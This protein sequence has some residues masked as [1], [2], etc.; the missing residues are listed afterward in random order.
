MPWG[1]SWPP[2]RCD[3][4]DAEAVFNEVRAALLERDG[5]VPAGQVPPAFARFAPL[6]GTPKGGTP[7]HRTVAN[8][9]H[10]IQ[11]MLDLVWPLRWWDPTRETLYVLQAL[12]QDAFGRDGWTHDLTGD[13]PTR[14]TPAAALVFDELYRAVNR[15]DRLRV[16]PTVSERLRHDSVYRLSFGIEDWPQDR[17]DTFSLF[18]GADDGV[19]TGLEYDVGM[20]GEVCDDGFSQQWILE[21]RRFRMTF[22]TGALAGYTVGG[23]RLDFTTAA[24]AGQ[25]DYED[26]FTAEVVDG[27]GE[28]VESFASGDYGPK[29]IALA[30]ESVNTSGESV[31]EVRSSRPDSNDRPA[32]DAPG[33]NYTSTYR[34]GLA[35]VG[36]VRLIVEVAF[37]YHG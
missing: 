9:Q 26:T 15:L 30:P 17:A 22:A 28:T 34:E 24:P 23:A 25:A 13:P 8:F 19:E 7:P 33:P 2:L 18:D 20:G 35:V 10:E 36:P 16:L 37:E 32:W 14:W 6:R 31:F 1:D 5:L 29:A 3:A 12:C 11:E 27:R 21:S 4:L